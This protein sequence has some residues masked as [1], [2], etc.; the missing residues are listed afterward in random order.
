MSSEVKSFNRKVV[1]LCSHARIQLLI[2]VETYKLKLTVCCVHDRILFSGEEVG[3]KDGDD[4]RGQ[5][6]EDRGA[7]GAQQRPLQQA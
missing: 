1:S 4:E 6:Q 7:A 2:L 3:D 5:G